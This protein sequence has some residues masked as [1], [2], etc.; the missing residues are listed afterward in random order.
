MTAELL[1]VNGGFGFLLDWA[2][3]NFFTPQLFAL[4]IISLLMGAAGN[5]L[6]SILERRWVR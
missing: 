2:A 5:S 6:F 3:F 4:V 1:V